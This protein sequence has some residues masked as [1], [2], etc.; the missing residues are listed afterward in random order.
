MDKISGIVPAGRRFRNVDVSRS[1]P[2]R[3]GA[4]SF[5]RPIGRASQADSF[6]ADV[7]AMSAPMDRVNISDDA[8]V[9]SSEMPGLKENIESFSNSRAASSR[10]NEVSTYSAPTK[11]VAASTVE[12]MTKKF[13]S[14]QKF[15]DDSGLKFEAAPRLS[16]PESGDLLLDSPV[17]AMANQ[18]DFSRQK[19]YS[20]SEQSL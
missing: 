6:S 2:V 4:P 1:Q 17:N 11:P 15:S 12:E 8:K 13:F 14:P 7:T 16:Q 9:Q 20:S 18:Q 5:G 10:A 19:P 3:P